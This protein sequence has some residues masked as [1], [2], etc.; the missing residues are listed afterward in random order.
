MS[1]DGQLS[2][3]LFDGEICHLLQAQL[4]RAVG[5]AAGRRWRDE[6]DAGLRALLFLLSFGGGE[7]ISEGQRLQNVRFDPQTKN[8]SVRLALLGV[9][10]VALPYAWTRAREAQRHNRWSEQRDW[11][12]GG[13]SRFFS[14]LV[15]FLSSLSS[16]RQRPS[17]RCGA[18][19]QCGAA[20][21]L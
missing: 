1:R 5:P 16:S 12:A 10:H 3:S 15:F 17:R 20:R 13:A 19:R 6:M 18:Q 4:A 21:A 9:A 2:S 11:R 8:L 7:R 14:P